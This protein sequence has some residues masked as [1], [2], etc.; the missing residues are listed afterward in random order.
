MPPTL[1]LEGYVLCLCILHTFQCQQKLNPLNRI[2][3]TLHAFNEV[4]NIILSIIWMNLRMQNL[5][6]WHRNL[7]FKF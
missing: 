4:E 5:T 2:K 3:Y 7:A 1:K 6:F